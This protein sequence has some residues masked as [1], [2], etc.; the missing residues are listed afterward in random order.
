MNRTETSNLL[1]A[2]S[3]LW[4][5]FKPEEGTLIAWSIAFRNIEYRHAEQALMY[6]FET[7]ELK[8]PPTANEIYHAVKKL[9]QPV[10]ESLSPEEAWSLVV[11]T[12][13][14]YGFYRELEAMAAMPAAVRVA[15]TST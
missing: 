9:F 3:G 4:P 11:Q 8:F 13:R 12:I 7:E 5:N 6:L 10:E 2:V 15:A 14:K 1:A